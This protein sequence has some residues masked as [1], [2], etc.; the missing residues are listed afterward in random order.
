LLEELKVF[1]FE[2]ALM[3]NELTTATTQLPET[4]ED[5]TQF[6]LVGKA[7]L[8]AYMLKLQTVNKLSVAQGIRDQTLKE[9]QE[10]S[11]ALIAA[12]QRIGE[13]LLAIPKASGQYAK[14]ENRPESKNTV[15]KDMGYSK[16][17]ASDYQQMAKHPEVVKKVMEDALANGEVVTKSSVMREIKFYKNR[18]ADLEKKKNPEPEI[19]EVEV[20]VVPDDYEESKKD[21]KKFKEQAKTNKAAYD[22]LMTKY[23]KKCKEALELQD[24]VNEL[25]HVTQEGLESESLSE[26]IFYFCTVCNNFIGNVGGLVWLVDRINDMSAKEK[27]MFLKA[28]RAFRDWALVFTQRLEENEEFMQIFERIEQ[29]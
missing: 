3:M 10:I 21:A 5:L 27:E 4:I 9:A 11:N 25:Q 22:Q 18:I 20:E 7:K 14:S 6:V 2:E 16:D 1:N 24:Q 26:N 29:K 28:S 8:Q 19:R 12:E 23:T 15:I 17:E 13:L